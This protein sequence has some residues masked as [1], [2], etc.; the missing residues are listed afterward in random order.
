[1]SPLLSGVQVSPVDITHVANV[2]TI[3][4]KNFSWI[5]RRQSLYDAKVDDFRSGRVN[6]HRDQIA[7]D[8]VSVNF[9]FEIKLHSR[10]SNFDRCA[11][12]QSCGQGTGGDGTCQEL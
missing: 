7:G 12:D 9:L 6:N 1:M 5:G 4:E 2:Q 10:I 11:M 8:S 3:R